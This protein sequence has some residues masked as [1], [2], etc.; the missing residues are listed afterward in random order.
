M[1]RYALEARHL[2][3]LKTDIFKI[4]RETHGIEE[5]SKD[6]INYTTNDVIFIEKTQGSGWFVFLLPLQ[7][8]HFG[9]YWILSL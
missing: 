6:F 5:N 2:W 1:K 9:A 8:L 4:L 7:G 3:S